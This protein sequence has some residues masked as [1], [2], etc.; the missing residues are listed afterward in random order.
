MLLLPWQPP[1]TSQQRS[2]FWMT[3]LVL[4]MGLL[5][6]L[7][8]IASLNSGFGPVWARVS[9]LLGMWQIGLA[10]WIMTIP[11]WSALRVALWSYALLAAFFGG[12]LA[13]T[14]ATPSGQVLPWDLT[15][16]RGRAI[17][18]SGGMAFFCLLAAYANG[19]L[20][21]RWQ[22][23]VRKSLRALESSR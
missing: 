1:T 11:D 7:P 4:T 19:T 12:L 8:G 10:I 15:E 17:P 2:L 9:M 6:M 20:M 14:M 23:Q 18:W 21:S 13:V 16:V 5:S 3:L 22:K